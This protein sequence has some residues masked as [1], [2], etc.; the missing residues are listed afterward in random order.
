MLKCHG[1]TEIKSFVTARV[2][3][4]IDSDNESENSDDDFEPDFAAD[5]D[6]NVPSDSKENGRSVKRMKDVYIF[7]LCFMV[8]WT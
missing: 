2:C 1:I 4:G 8:C 6:K 5:S 7:I 3:M